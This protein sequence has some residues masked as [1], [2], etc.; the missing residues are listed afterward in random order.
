MITYVKMLAKRLTLK[1]GDYGKWL[2]IWGDSDE[3]VTPESAMKLSTWF[4]GKRLITETV[5]T[6]PGG[7][8]RTKGDDREAARDHDVHQ[9]LRQ[10]PNDE[11]TDVE[12]MEGRVGP[13]ISRGNSYAEIR[14]IGDRPVSL[15]PMAVDDTEPFRD[16]DNNK[17]KYR[18][19]DRGRQEV[20]P[21][22]KVLHIRGFGEDGLVGF[23]PI[24]AA[25]MSLAGA[26]AT[27]RTA[28]RI[29]RK[30][31]R[32]AGFFKAPPMDDAE[33]DEF[34]KNYIAP[35]EGVKGAG[36][37]PI[38]PPSIEW[39]S[40]NITPHDAEMLLSRRFNVE[41]VCR[42]LG[43][44]PILVGHAAEG[45]TMWGT[46]IEQ[47]ILG[48]LVLGLRA[49]LKRIESAIN[50]RL[51]SPADRR[52]GVFFEF[53]VEGLLRGDSAARM[54]LMAQAAQNGLRNRNELRRLDN[55][56]GFEGGDQFTVQSNLITLE[57]LGEATS[58]AN[59]VRT[60]LL[61]WLS[62]ER[63]EAA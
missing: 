10:T 61:N 23:S 1:A 18:F 55:Y 4:A 45:Q 44:P 49:Y 41:D 40:A 3:W 53:N 35:F 29:Y 48:W 11:Q 17:I 59:V 60:A 30:G 50:R 24:E 16:P 19:N 34:Y 5:A 31:L 22:E 52:A 2:Q 42:W 14:S 32:A 51:I 38:L 58:N 36:R 26:I 39:Q 25:R 27:E 6:L 12:F 21:A 57:R 20:L 43:L 47:I 8:Y 13:L 33:R 54:Q 63:K 62:E 46:G 15:L 56:P 37:S 7:V 9:L 28:G